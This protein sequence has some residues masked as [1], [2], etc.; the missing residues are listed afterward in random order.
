[1]RPGNPSS[2]RP[3]MRASSQPAQRIIVTQVRL[4]GRH[5]VIHGLSPRNSAAAPIPSE[6]KP[7]ELRAVLV[8][9]DQPAAGGG[10]RREALERQI[11]IAQVDHHRATEDQ[12]EAA[13]LMRASRRR[14]ASRP[15]RPCCREPRGRSR[16]PRRGRHQRPAAAVAASRGPGRRRCRGRSRWRRGAPSRT[17]RSPRT[18]RRPGPASRPSRRAGRSARHAGRRSNMPGVTSPGASSWVWYQSIFSA[19]GPS[20]SIACDRVGC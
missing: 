18:C 12:V 2:K 16:S 1:M 17:P 13:E 9:E 7:V 11:W 14:S 20:S 10:E 3:W 5:Q 4:A 15:A 6:A 8:G 19:P